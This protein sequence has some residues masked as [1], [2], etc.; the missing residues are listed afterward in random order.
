MRRY[1]WKD[2]QF[3]MSYMNWTR[4]MT[5]RTLRVVS[6]VTDPFGKK[7]KKGY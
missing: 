6:E 3:G 1:M 4:I 5:M 2:V 7:Y